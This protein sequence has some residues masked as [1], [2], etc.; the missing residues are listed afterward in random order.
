MFTVWRHSPADANWKVTSF[1]FTLWTDFQE[2][3]VEERIEPINSRYRSGETEGS[4]I[5]FSLSLTLWH[6]ATSNLGFLREYCI[7]L[8][9]DN[10][11]Y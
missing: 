8:D 4:R 6:R 5:Y 10:Q 11:G 7:D 9:D 3:W 2:A 1:A